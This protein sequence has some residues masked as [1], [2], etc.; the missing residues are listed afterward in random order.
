MFSGEKTPRIE[1]E[2]QQRR[3][4]GCLT[5]QK[6]EESSPGHAKKIGDA[7]MGEKN[8]TLKLT[9]K[10]VDTIKKIYIS[11]RHTYKSISKMFPNVPCFFWGYRE[12]NK[13]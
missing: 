5:L 3:E 11:G 10:D 7:Q 4:K 1:R 8:H 2:C 12:S 9:K 6:E 13:R